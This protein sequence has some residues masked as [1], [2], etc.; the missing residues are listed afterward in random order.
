MLGVFNAPM[1]DWLNGTSLSGSY[2]YN[3]I[4]GN[5][6][7]ATFGFLG[8][9]Q[10]NNSVPISALLDLLFTNINNICI[11]VSNYSMATLITINSHLN[12]I[13]N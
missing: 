12:L 5:L 6:I 3:R 1:Y 11:S 10:H 13:S 4:K 8:L 9:N 7:H 2:Y